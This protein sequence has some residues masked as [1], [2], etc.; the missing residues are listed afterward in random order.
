MIF[1][2][3]FNTSLFISSFLFCFAVSYNDT[4]HRL[5][6]RPQA[7]GEMY[8][9]LFRPSKAVIFFLHTGSMTLTHETKANLK[10]KQKKPKTH[11][12]EIGL[13]T[14]TQ[15]KDATIF[16]FC[17]PKVTIQKAFREENWATLPSDPTCA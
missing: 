16:F 14:V 8:F 9:F 1:S 12:P 13:E 6:V 4:D 17:Q 10:T 7:N 11:R 2:R 3:S 15:F 5:R